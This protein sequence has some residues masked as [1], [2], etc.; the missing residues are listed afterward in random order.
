MPLSSASTPN[1]RELNNEELWLATLS[2]DYELNIVACR[3]ITAGADPSV[4]TGGV[5][6]SS[7]GMVL[8]QKWWGCLSKPVAQC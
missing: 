4:R 7:L 2:R 5:S 3:R 6:P 1:D 8:A